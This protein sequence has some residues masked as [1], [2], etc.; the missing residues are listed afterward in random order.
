MTLTERKTNPEVTAMFVETLT[1][2]EM[3]KVSGGGFSDVV[4]IMW[5]QA[6][7]EFGFHNMYDAGLEYQTM[8]FNL[9]CARTVRRCCRCNYEEVGEWHAVVQRKH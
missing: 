7:C 3:E 9:L 5:N 2:P 4:N 6:K 1:Q 8:Y